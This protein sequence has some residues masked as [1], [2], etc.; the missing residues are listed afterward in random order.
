MMSVDCHIKDATIKK[1]KKTLP[2]SSVSSFCPGAHRSRGLRKKR[3]STILRRKTWHPSGRTLGSTYRS[4][5]LREGALGKPSGDSAQGPSHEKGHHSGHQQSRNH[6]QSLECDTHAQCTAPAR[7]A[8]VTAHGC[9]AV[10]QV[11]PPPPRPPS[12]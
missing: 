5:S 11:C 4:L 1:K 2:F 10:S 12:L 3:Y 8:R 9:V 7:V 6:T